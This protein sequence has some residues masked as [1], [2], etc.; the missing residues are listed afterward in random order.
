M[1]LFKSTK[2]LN[3]FVAYCIIDINPNDEQ[4][5]LQALNSLATILVRDHEIVVVISITVITCS[6][7][8]EPEEGDS[9][10]YREG[11]KREGDREGEGEEQGKEEG[12]EEGEEEGESRGGEEKRDENFEGPK[13]FAAIANPCTISDG[14]TGYILVFPDI[15][16]ATISLYKSSI[17]LEYP[18]RF[19]RHQ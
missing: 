2:H 13:T 10:K 8:R 6:E 14:G 12:K 7:D 11:K 3:G 1:Y 5:Y 15:G 17:Q 18:M 4:P 19:A 16:P 9:D